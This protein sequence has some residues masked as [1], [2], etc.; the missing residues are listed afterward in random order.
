[1]LLKYAAYYLVRP[2]RIFG[3]PYR[4]ILGIMFGMSLLM[5]PISIG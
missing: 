5:I 4:M 2:F 3:V 1:M